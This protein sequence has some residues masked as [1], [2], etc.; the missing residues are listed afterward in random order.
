M[1]ENS[2]LGENHNCTIWHGPVTKDG[3]YGLVSFLNPDTAS[4][5]KKKAHRF[6]YMLHIKDLNLTAEYDC[7][8]L[9]H[10]SLCIN[11]DHISLEPHHINNNRIHCRNEMNC[12]GHGIYPAC[13]LDLEIH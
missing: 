10:N 4:W 7:S 3:K 1:K 13:R 11:P 2:H 5:Q 9:C 8:H 6:N 12:S